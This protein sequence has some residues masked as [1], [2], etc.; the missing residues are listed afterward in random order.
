MGSICMKLDLKSLGLNIGLSSGEIQ[1][2]NDLQL[3]SKTDPIS[4]LFFLA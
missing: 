1:W 3:K 2:T 4:L